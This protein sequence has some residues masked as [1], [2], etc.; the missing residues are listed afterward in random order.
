MMSHPKTPFRQKK[1]EAAAEGTETA[2]ATR[3]IYGG[4]GDASTSILLTEK[5]RRGRRGRESV[6][7]GE[8]G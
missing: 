2:A 3:F 4:E 7:K 1:G 5:R 8:E 6:K